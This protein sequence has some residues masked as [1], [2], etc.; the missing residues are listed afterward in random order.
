MLYSNERGTDDRQSTE[1]GFIYQVRGGREGNKQHK[2]DVES[3]HKF[4][5]LVIGS[6]EG[7]NQLKVCSRY[8]NLG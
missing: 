8:T 2:V 1:D 5:Y 4:N 3:T 7:Y 6:I